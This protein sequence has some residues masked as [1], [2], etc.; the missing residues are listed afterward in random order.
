MPAILSVRNAFRPATWS[1][2]AA[3][4]YREVFRTV[5]GIYAI[6]Q[7]ALD[8]FLVIFGDYVLPGTVTEIIHNSVD[9]RRFKPDDAR[10]I[11]ARRML[12]LPQ[13]TLVI[14]AADRLEKQ[15]R[16]DKLITVFNE[17]KMNFPNLYLVLVGT[18][19]LEPALK[20]QTRRLGIRDSVVFT[21]WQPAVD[22]ILPAFDLAI[23]LSRNEGFG[24]STIEAMACALPVVATDVPGTRDILSSGE[25]GILVPEDDVKATVAACQNLLA[26]KTIRR[27]LGPKGR[28]ESVSKYDE[29]IWK[30]KIFDFYQNVFDSMGSR[31]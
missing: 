31:S 25:G 30:N 4:H 17:L 2:K 20:K 26:N 24:T 15:K 13:D 12:E 29:R 14:G 27:Q 18:G 1:E 19:S 16:P 6:S 28:R 3:E 22:K 9:T 7:N 11:A 5:R 23:Q 8:H 10:R 21:G